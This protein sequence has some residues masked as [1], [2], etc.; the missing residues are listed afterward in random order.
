M[1]QRVRRFFIAIGLISALVSPGAAQPLDLSGLDL[2]V[3][4]DLDL[5]G[6]GIPDSSSA[7][8]D[9][10]PLGQQGALAAV[11]SNRALPL[12]QIM[13]SARL[14]ADGEIIDARLIEISQQLVY[15]LKVLGKS[16]NVSALYFYARSGDL[17]T[18]N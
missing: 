11:R 3:D 13:A 4:L 8:L 15:E 2:G 12:S 7:G 16:G 14:I 6:D 1:R 18:P 17:I 9:L 5:D 10:Q